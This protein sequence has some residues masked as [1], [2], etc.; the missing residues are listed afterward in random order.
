MT[1]GQQPGYGYPAAQPQFEPPAHLG[2]AVLATIIGTLT[3]LV[4]TVLGM[5]AIV[6][7]TQVHS[8]WIA[9][10]IAGA[11]DASKKARGWGIAAM[12]ANVLC[13]V[14][15]LGYLVVTLTRSSSY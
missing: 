1:Y 9:G 5:V 2:F 11:M 3:C 10:D 8:K 4:G 7:G 13:V 15:A 12:V 6:F 14:L